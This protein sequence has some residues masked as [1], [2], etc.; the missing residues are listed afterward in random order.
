MLNALRKE[1][2]VSHFTLDEAIHMMQLFAPDQ[3]YLIHLSHQMGLHAEVEAGLPKG[4]KV[5]YDGMVVRN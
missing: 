5:A 4:I 2:H 1:P 3:G